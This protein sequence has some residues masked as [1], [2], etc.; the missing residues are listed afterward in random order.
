MTTQTP[1]TFSDEVREFA[2]E[3]VT[4]RPRKERFKPSLPTDLV[5]EVVDEAPVK[6][7][8]VEEVPVEAPVLTGWKQLLAISRSSPKTF[9]VGTLSPA[10]MSPKSPMSDISDISTA[11]EE[12]LTPSTDLST[13]FGNR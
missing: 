2:F 4:R 11:T 10:A 13:R 9:L 5:E 6:K 8:P 3:P 1:K 7:A 12:E